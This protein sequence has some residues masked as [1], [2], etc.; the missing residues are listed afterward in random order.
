MILL[1]DKWLYISTMKC[2]TN[3]LYKD[4]KAQ[5][6]GAEWAGGNNFHAIPSSSS[7]PIPV[8]GT[9]HKADCGEKVRLAPLHWT[10]VRNPY[11]R[12]VSIWASTCVRESNRA[13]YEPFELIKAAGGDPINFEDFV[14]HV[15]LPQPKL[16]VPWLYR[17][18]SE[19]V[20]QFICD[21]FLHLETLEADLEATLGQPIKLSMENTS[22]HDEWKGYYTEPIKRKVLTWAGEDFSKFGYSEHSGCMH[23]LPKY[24]G[25]EV[26]GRAVPGAEESAATLDE[27]LLSR[28]VG[29]DIY[30]GTVNIALL[31]DIELGNPAFS[32]GVYSIWPCKI[33]GDEWTGPQG[34]VDAWVLHIDGEELPPNYIEVISPTC[35]REHL[36]M[37]DFPSFIVKLML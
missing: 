5:V 11:A 22:E 32:V 14:N 30:P 8:G 3:S 18:Q 16:R 29:V 15:L 6:L 24:L 33:D 19:W 31:Q 25:T 10:V 34:W 20:S 35:I 13:K 12:A 26:K 2:A 21:K 9:K 17:N 23:T 7:H 27:G 28:M 4:L 1:P 36:N 37:Q